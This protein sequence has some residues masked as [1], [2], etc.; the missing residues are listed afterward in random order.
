MVQIVP[1][2]IAFIHAGVK[3]VDAGKLSF[4]LPARLI[5][6]LEGLWRSSD[7]VGIIGRPWYDVPAPP[8]SL[9]SLPAPQVEGLLSERAPWYIAMTDEFL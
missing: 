4:D 1:D 5:E 2:D 9:P 6:R 3:E 7:A 8:E